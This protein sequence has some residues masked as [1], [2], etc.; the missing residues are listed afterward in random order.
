MEY[1]RHFISKKRVS[2][3]LRKVEAV[4]QWPVPTIIKQLMGLLGLTRYHRRL[5]RDYG[6]IAKP[7]T[8]LCKPTGALKWTI[9]AD[10]AFRE[11]KEAMINT[12]VL[13]LPNFSQKF[14][15]ETDAFGSGI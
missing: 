4:K 14:V 12:L 8:T 7:L 11:L 6:R 9:K 5:V 2:T 10:Q 1:L 15:I 13:A 3:D